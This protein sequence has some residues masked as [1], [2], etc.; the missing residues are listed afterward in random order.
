MQAL[1]KTNFWDPAFFHQV[2]PGL[3]T[4][5]TYET[6]FQSCCKMWICRL[7][8]V[9]FTPLHRIAR[10][11]CVISG[12]R[13]EVAENCALLCY[14]TESTGNFLPNKKE[15][16]TSR[17]VITQKSAVLSCSSCIAGIPEQ[18]ASEVTDRTW[19][20]SSLACSFP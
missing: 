17:C 11:S 19:W 4:T 7:G 8:F 9:C 10:S 1:K 12:F 14:C 18:R 13:R 5:I 2:C 6:S 3:F 16:T 20:T 15:I